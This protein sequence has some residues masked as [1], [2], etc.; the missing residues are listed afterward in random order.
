MLSP[1]LS[2]GRVGTQ[3]RQ[4]IESNIALHRHGARVDSEDVRAPFQVGQAELHLAVQAAGPH[5]RRV[6]GVGPV[7]SHQH[8]KL[9]K[10]T[11]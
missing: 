10:K 5:E 7:C 3:S 2:T 4:Q 6:Q 8:L 1:N 11:L 9:R